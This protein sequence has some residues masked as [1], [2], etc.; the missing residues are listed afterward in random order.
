MLVSS[1]I[2]LQLLYILNLIPKNI[3]KRMFKKKDL[4][5][6]YNI[7]HHLIGDLA[8]LYAEVV[9]RASILS[10]RVIQV[11]MFSNWVQTAER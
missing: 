6:Q 9:Q 5:F 4:F 7:A 11:H 1:A 8:L 10:L 3:Q 2:M